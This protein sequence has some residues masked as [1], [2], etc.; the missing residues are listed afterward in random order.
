MFALPS[1]LLACVYQ[2]LAPTADQVAAARGE[3]RHTAYR[4]QIGQYGSSQQRPRQPED[5][6]FRD[7]DDLEFKMEMDA[8][9]EFLREKTRTEVL[10]RVIDADVERKIDVVRHVLACALVCHSGHD[11][12][13]AWMQNLTNGDALEE[14]ALRRIRL[15][16]TR[17]DS[18]LVDVLA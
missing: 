9:D 6:A 17:T 15:W 4:L 13:R 1:D 14:V 18:I 3:V 10:M 16:Q 11:A 12:V 5:D 2:Q 7:E 8:E